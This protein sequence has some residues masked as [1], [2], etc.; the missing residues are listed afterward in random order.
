MSV[1][2]N[3]P[4]AISFSQIQ[5]EFTGSSLSSWYRGGSLVPNTGTNASIPTSGSISLSQFYGAAKTPPYT[6]KIYSFTTGGTISTFT[7]PAGMTSIAILMCGGGGGGGGSYASGKWEGGGGGGGGGVLYVPSVPVS[8]GQIL[9]ITVGLGG[10]SGTYAGGNGGNSSIVDGNNGTTY[11]T[12]PGGGGGGNGDYNTVN[13]AN[14]YG[15]PTRV[16]SGFGGGSGG[17]ASGSDYNIQGGPGKIGFYT[18]PGYTAYTYGNSGGSAMD[19]SW[20]GGGGG[21]STT[22]NNDNAVSRFFNTGSPTGSTLVPTWQYNTS[23]TTGPYV[24]FSSLSGSVSPWFANNT[25]NPQGYYSYDSSGSSRYAYPSPI[26]SGNSTLS[27]AGQGQDGYFSGSGTSGYLGLG[28]SGAGGDGITLTIGGT[29]YIM[30]AGGG[31]GAS[32]VNGSGSV[33]TSYC[34]TDAQGAPGGIGG[35][36]KGGQG[37][38]NTTSAAIVNGGA[39]AGYG[40]G[41]GGAGGTI[42]GSRGHV[43]TYGGAGSPGAVFIYG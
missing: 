12:A 8:A 20:N 34:P 33:Q 21:A 31:A 37:G 4:A 28:F 3:P 11:Y 40:S 24:N 41:G 36:G 9:K 43:S 39:G 30:G 32:W 6:P 18:Y 19:N 13:V 27:G 10:A 25:A 2:T 23:A 5:T 42:G 29:N 7:V 26:T 22:T 1:H 15:Q 14:T 17:G 38:T 16:R 35:G